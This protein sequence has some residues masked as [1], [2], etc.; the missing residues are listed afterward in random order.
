MGQTNGENI[1]RGWAHLNEL[2]PPTK[3]M[4]PGA[5]QDTTNAHIGSW[6]KMQMVKQGNIYICNKNVLLMK[7]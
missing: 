6:N 7:Q 4:A 1:E 2:S 5:R 3:E